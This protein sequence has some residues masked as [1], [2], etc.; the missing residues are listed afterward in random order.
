MRRG[1]GVAAIPGRR[2]RCVA[3][4]A[5]PRFGRRDVAAVRDGGRVGDET[6]A[7]S[8]RACATGRSSWRCTRRSTGGR[9]EVVDDP[10]SRNIHVVAAAVPR[11]VSAE[12]PRDLAAP[13]Q[14]PRGEVRHRGARRVFPAG[15][16]HRGPHERRGAGV[17]APRRN[18][19]RWLH[20]SRGRRQRPNAAKVSGRRP[21]SLEF[22]LAADRPR[23]ITGLGII[24]VAAAAVPRPAPD[25]AGTSRRSS[26]SSTA[27]TRR[28]ATSCAPGGR[29]S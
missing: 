22:G 6:Q 26:A 23:T 5:S 1:R 3:A 18:P 4:A 15:R 24:R 20:P 13:S 25:G 9:A 2:G 14:V 28:A 8:P 29:H 12:Y 17:L 11:P 19:A 21:S 16:R 27:S 7:S 10:S